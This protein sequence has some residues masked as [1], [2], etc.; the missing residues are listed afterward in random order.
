MKKQ[1]LFING[2]LNAGGCERSL[3]DLLRNIN[4]KKY[5]VDL[6]LLENLGDYF[7][8][9]PKEVNVIFYPLGNAF[10]S[11]RYCMLSAIK[12][13]DWFSFWYRLIHLYS[14]KFGIEKLKHTRKLFKKVKN[15][16]DAIIAYRPGVCT[17]L[18]AFAFSA[19]K[20]IS[21][22]HHGE[23]NL[24]ETQISK[25]DKVYS[26]VDTI[27]AVSQSSEAIVLSNF[28]NSTNKTCVI[29]NMICTDELIA[30]SRAHID[31]ADDKSLL[32]IVTVGRMSPEKNMLL[33]PKIAQ[34]LIYHQCK[35]IWYMIGDGEE[36]SA[37]QDEIAQNGLSDKFVLTG[38][39]ENPY[40]YI[41]K[42][43]VLLHP[44]LVESQGLTIL[45]AMV[46]E[47]PVVVVESAGPKEFIES[48]K[49]GFLL[50]CNVDSICKTISSKAWINGSIISEAKKTVGEISPEKIMK[51]FYE[52][53]ENIS[54]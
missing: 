37:L 53:V 19:D 24:S 21:W 42:A 14:T 12:K 26:E 36:M 31:F 3:T 47:T 54:N 33:C 41:Y 51:Y 13:R 50:P 6:L 34:K 18:A 17:D 44:S 46:L 1:L 22:W 48:G 16:Y 5:D 49:N 30:K 8:E 4:Y 29:P 15:H 7:E 52:I 39:L 23:L 10:G 45:E 27:V 2:H 40:P 11:F 28:K 43:D 35:F 38:R 9:L 25:L 32:K 20:K